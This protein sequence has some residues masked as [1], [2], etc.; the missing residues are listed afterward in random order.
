MATR[1][2]K[3]THY[4]THGV[5]KA[6][7]PGSGSLALPYVY[8]RHRLCIT[9]QRSRSYC[10]C[11]RLATYRA[12]PKSQEP[13][14]FNVC[15]F[16]CHSNGKRSLA[17]DPFDLEVSPLIIPIENTWIHS[18][19]SALMLSSFLCTSACST[20][21]SIFFFI[22]SSVIFVII[23]ENGAV[24]TWVFVDFLWKLR[25]DEYCFTHD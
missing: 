23:S 16:S 10:I 4:F 22:S 3:T 17:N 21:F 9:D 6:P 8:H 2:S 19:S 1:K 7:D 25:G 15:M 13:A 20:S 12:E 24:S 14:L 18:N 5:K 11:T